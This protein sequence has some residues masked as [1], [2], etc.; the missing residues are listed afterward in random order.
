MSGSKYIPVNL[1]L[2]LFRSCPDQNE[3]Y[4]SFEAS[5]QM[6]WPIEHCGNVSEDTFWVQLGQCCD[7]VLE[8]KCKVIFRC[9]E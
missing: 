9:M 5:R 7:N 3:A 1:G 2:F 4:A 8:G 6:I